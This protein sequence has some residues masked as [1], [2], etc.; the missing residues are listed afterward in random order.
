M[1]RD[2]QTLRAVLDTNVYLSDLLFGGRPAALVNEGLFGS[3]RIVCSVP[4]LFEFREK[5]ESKFG[6]SP[7]ETQ[8]LLQSLLLAMS[9]VGVNIGGTHPVIDDVH[10]FEGIVT[11]I[12][13]I[14]TSAHK[15]QFSDETYRKGKEYV[16]DFEDFKGVHT[17]DGLVSPGQRLELEK[18]QDYGSERDVRV[19]IA[20]VA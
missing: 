18:L 15:Y 10:V 1:T 20:E 5:L 16:D 11:S 7:K 17:K 4:I 12:K 2:T 9:I 8:S 6:W 13:T 14:D 3:Y 19:V